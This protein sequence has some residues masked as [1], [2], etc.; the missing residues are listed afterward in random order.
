M[1]SLF[2]GARSRAVL[3]KLLIAMVLSL[4]LDKF[5]APLMLAHLMG[6]DIQIRMLIVWMIL[7]RLRSSWGL[8]SRSESGC[9]RMNLPSSYRGLGASMGF[10]PLA[11]R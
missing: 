6:L 5:S 3:L 2:F 1:M 11:A 8:L 10:I 7:P 4:V 9:S